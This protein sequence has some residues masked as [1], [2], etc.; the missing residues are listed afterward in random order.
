MAAIAW[1]QAS[2]IKYSGYWFKR[3]NKT[4]QSCAFGEFWL[5]TYITTI[6]IH[7]N[8]QDT[9]MVEM[10]TKKRS[11]RIHIYKYK[12]KAPAEQWRVIYYP[13]QG[14]DLKSLISSLFS[15]YFTKNAFFQY[16]IPRYVDQYRCGKS[17]NNNRM[18][19]RIPFILPLLYLFVFFFHSILF[20]LS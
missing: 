15:F 16:Q 20:T 6:T 4:Y 2:R 12:Y 17:H 1:L 8:L 10:F 5:S 11:Y 7:H 19:K 13:W 18:V 3:I 14:L 9:N